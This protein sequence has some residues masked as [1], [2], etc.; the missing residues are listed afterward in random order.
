MISAYI[1]R[2]RF[3]VKMDRDGSPHR[4]GRKIQ[5]SD[6]M[7]RDIEW[8]VLESPLFSFSFSNKEKSSFGVNE[9]SQFPRHSFQED[10]ILLTWVS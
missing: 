10:S 5:T 8:K 6:H 1:Q 2:E 9:G 3:N 7:T 4:D